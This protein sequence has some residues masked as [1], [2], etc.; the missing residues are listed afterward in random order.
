MPDLGPKA[1]ALAGLLVALASIAH[2]ACIAVGPRAYRFMGAGERMARAVEAGRLKPT[3]ITLGIASILFIW[4]LYAFSGAGM[5]PRLPFTELALLLISLVFLAR[6]IA[7]PILKPRFP[8]NSTTFWLVSSGIC[9]LI[10]LL[11]AIGLVALIAR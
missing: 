2:L 5:A 9:L 1:L 7:Y 11:Y 3:L 8:G 6:A 10:G 4:A